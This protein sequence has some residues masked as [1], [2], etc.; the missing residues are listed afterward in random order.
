MPGK[1]DPRYLSALVAHLRQLGTKRPSPEE[2]REVEQHLSNKWQG[3]QS[4]AAQVIAGWG[5][6]EAVHALRELL[7]RSYEKPHWWAIRGVAARQL[8]K[9]L[10]ETDAEWVLDHYF[11]QP[12]IFTKHRTASLVWGLPVEAARA[13]LE[14][15]LLSTDPENRRAALGAI[16]WMPF[17]DKVALLRRLEND[18]EPSIQDAAQSWIEHLTAD[19]QNGT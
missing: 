18:P 2:R 7:M 10:D 16:V 17:P 5:G 4:V 13:R 19:S 9:C 6:R 12:N 3:V 8:A 11:G 1:G 15:E 14:A